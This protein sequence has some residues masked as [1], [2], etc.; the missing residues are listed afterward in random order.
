MSIWYYFSTLKTSWLQYLSHYAQ[1]YRDTQWWGSVVSAQ[2]W[3][4]LSQDNELIIALAWD[5]KAC[6]LVITSWSTRWWENKSL[7]PLLL[8]MFIRDQGHHASMLRWRLDNC[9]N[10]N[11]R[12]R[13]AHYWSYLYTYFSIPFKHPPMWIVSFLYASK[14]YFGCSLLN[15]NT[16]ALGWSLYVSL[17]FHSAVTPHTIQNGIICHSFIHGITNVLASYSS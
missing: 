13:K 8:L 4:P 16:S 6:F 12:S 17:L 11:V 5:K 7:F 3:L 14:N 15:S 2:Y 1:S 9:S 10:K